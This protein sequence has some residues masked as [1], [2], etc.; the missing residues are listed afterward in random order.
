LEAN[1]SFP[2]I[3]DNPWM[4]IAA[5]NTHQDP[6]VPAYVH[7]S[8]MHLKCRGI[9]AVAALV[10]AACAPMA[11]SPELAQPR[12]AQ[13]AFPSKDRIG[14]WSVDKFTGRYM[15]GMKALTV[16]RDDHRLLVE[17]WNLGTRQITADTVESWIWQ[18]ACGLRYEFTLPPDG[19][20]ARLKV[21][22]TNGITTDWHRS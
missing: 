7:P 15:H 2:P 19:P 16:R 4:V 1:V 12:C 14:A 9:V 18:D 3:P 21:T 10:P 22:E 8:M 11:R 5:I 20:G 6:S 17:G 13:M